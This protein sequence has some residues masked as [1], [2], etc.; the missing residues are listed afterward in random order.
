M[1]TVHSQDG[2]AIA[3]NQSGQGPAI[4]LVL[5]AFN[6]QATGAP[7]AELLSER[8]TVFNYDRR[9]RGKS[10]DTTPYAIVREIEDLAALIDA[11]GGSASVFGYSSGALLALM[12]AAHGLPITKLAL[13]EPPFLINDGLAQRGRDVSTRL[14]KMLSE[15]LQ[16]DAVELF[17]TEIVGIPAEIVS[18]LRYAPFRPALE[19][20]AQTLVYDASIL[21]NIDVLAE[22]LN[23]ITIPTLVISGEVSPT[24]LGDA[25]QAITDALPH[26]QHLRLTGQT[27][28][29]VASVL[30]PVL[31]TFFVNEPESE[32]M[33]K[34]SSM[35]EQ[36]Q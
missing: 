27:H 18:Q 3:F 34:T 11:A 16:G 36:G 35:T 24:M 13:Y 30:S 28:D 20:I 17:Q 23:A 33:M 9:G 10:G 5:G 25:A 21:G 7:L 12:A 22:Q 8:F 29:I 1:K 32:H 15:G 14:T 6:D 4:I 31:E 19:A 2:I 26:A